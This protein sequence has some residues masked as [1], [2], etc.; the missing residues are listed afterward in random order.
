MADPAPTLGLANHRL[1][2]WDQGAGADLWGAGRGGNEPMAPGLARDLESM[3]LNS[4]SS[5]GR[6][7]LFCGRGQSGLTGFLSALPLVGAIAAGLLLRRL[8]HCDE[9]VKVARNA[10]WFLFI[11]PTFFFNDT[12][13]T[14]SLFLA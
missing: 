13:S 6:I 10:V 11:F 1:G 8:V 12:A 5:P 9:N 7:R 14:E 2:P 3:G 4:L